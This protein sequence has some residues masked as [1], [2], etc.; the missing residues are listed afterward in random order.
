MN[1]PPFVTKSY[2]VCN[3]QAGLPYNK[4]DDGLCNKIARFG[5]RKSDAVCNKFL[6]LINF[7]F[8]D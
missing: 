3:R 1:I 7:I 8:L 5:Y 4:H 2:S 6:K